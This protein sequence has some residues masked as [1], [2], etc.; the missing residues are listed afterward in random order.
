MNAPAGRSLL[1]RSRWALAC[2]ALILFLCLLPGDELPEWDWF[3]LLDLDKVVHAGMFFA[4]AVLLAQAF[5]DGGRPARWAMWAVLLSAGNGVLTEVLQG[6]EALGR[7]TD[8]AD[9]LANTVGALAMVPY[10]G[11]CKRRARPFVPWGWLR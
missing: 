2:A 10:V 3:A 6:L 5:H 4:L 7:R 8:P 9:M 1:F 11:W